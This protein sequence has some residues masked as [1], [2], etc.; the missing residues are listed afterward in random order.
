MASEQMQLDPTP[1]QVEDAHTREERLKVATQFNDAGHKKWIQKALISGRK[2]II[3]NDEGE[4]IGEK[5]V[6]GVTRE[7]AAK[8]NEKYKLTSEQIEWKKKMGLKLLKDSKSPNQVTGRAHI[9]DPHDEEI[10]K[11]FNQEKE[12]QGVAVFLRWDK[13]S[14]QYAQQMMAPPSKKMGI[15][16]YRDEEVE[17][18]IKEAIKGMAPIPSLTWRSAQDALDIYA[19][20]I[21]QS[22]PIIPVP[23]NTPKLL[24]L[25]TGIQAPMV[26]NSLVALRQYIVASKLLMDNPKILTR[27]KTAFKWARVALEASLLE[28]EDLFKLLDHVEI[29]PTKKALINPADFKQAFER[30]QLKPEDF[31][32]LEEHTWIV[33]PYEA[34]YNDLG[35]P[36]GFAED[37]LEDASEMK[38]L[39]TQQVYQWLDANPNPSLRDFNRAMFKFNIDFLRVYEMQIQRLIRLP[40]AYLP[41]RGTSEEPVDPADIDPY[42]ARQMM[43][44]RAQ[45]AAVRARFVKDPNVPSLDLSIERAAM[46]GGYADTLDMDLFINWVAKRR[47]F[48]EKEEEEAYKEADSALHGLYQASS[49]RLEASIKK[50]VEEEDAEMDVEEKIEEIPMSVENCN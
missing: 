45:L 13:N 31:N 11:M 6:V 29:W 24:L 27:K 33:R 17:P 9:A 1:A 16:Q 48:A 37:V 41:D 3:R 49:D 38:E 2:V 7:L 19:D 22:L 26:Y 21:I 14:P 5:P 42:Y 4:V 36:C 23:I 40:P 39:A 46:G 35:A 34:P 25:V 8:L 50:E 43:T 30:G 10:W 28:K 18:E 32:R 44:N 47:S 12:Q 20:G 15:I